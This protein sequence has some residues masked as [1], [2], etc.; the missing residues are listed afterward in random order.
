MPQVL[1]LQDP[2]ARD[3]TLINLPKPIKLEFPRFKNEDPS[4]LGI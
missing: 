2:T 1:N 3:A 4:L